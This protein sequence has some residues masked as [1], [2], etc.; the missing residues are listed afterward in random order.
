MSLNDALFLEEQRK[1]AHLF[2][3]STCRSFTRKQIIVCA[4]GQF[5]PC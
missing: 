3:R 5:N 2:L 4:V 1:D